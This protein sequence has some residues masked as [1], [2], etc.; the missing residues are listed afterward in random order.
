MKKDKKALLS[1]DEIESILKEIMGEGYDN[2]DAR[3]MVCT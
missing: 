1:A 2:A 3:E